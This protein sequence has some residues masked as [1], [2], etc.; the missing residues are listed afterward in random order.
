MNN[1]GQTTILFSLITGILLLFTLTALEVGRIHLRT[2][3]IKPCV[4]SMRSSIMAD[5]NAELFEK[6][7]LLF[8]DPTYGTGSEAVLEEKIVDYL[9]TSLNGEE[10]S[11]VYQFQVEEVALSEMKTIMSDDMKLLKQQIKNYEST[12]GIANQIKDL[13]ADLGNGNTDLKDA[14]K[15]TEINGKELPISDENDDETEN[16]NVETEEEMAVKE[17]DYKDPRETLKESLKFGILSFVAQE[18]N[19]SKESYKLK[20]APSEKYEEVQKEERSR[21]FDDIGVLN[22]FLDEVTKENALGQLAENVSF[23]SYITSHFSNAMEQK[24]GAVMQCEAEYILKGKANDYDNVEAVIEEMTWSRMPLNYAYLLTD[25]EKKSQALTLATAISIVTGTEPFVE[26][27][28]YLLLACWAYGE[29]LYE[30]HV[31]LSGEQIAYIK[32]SGTWY[33]DL[34]TLTAVNNVAK[35][36]NG[37]SY[38][39]F[40]AILLVK[41]TGASL[42]KGYARILDVIQLNL[43]QDY[44]TFRIT[45]CVG[46]MTVQGKVSMN[47]LFQKTEE[48]GVYDY[49]FEEHLSYE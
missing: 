34:E 45:D 19:F 15:E 47:P 31:L 21:K 27:I 36:T 25:I 22:A 7:H 35:Q 12:A 26:V 5:Y 11:K 2:V 4:H 42:D 28:K 40:L 17:E 44:S 33:T 10:G 23:A 6:Y 1:K 41:K 14:A 16:T 39:D 9:E 18:K 37:L 30:M 24:E 46:S 43:M 32:T 48:E 29:S 3:K 49:Y 13:L 38:E 8:L 20:N